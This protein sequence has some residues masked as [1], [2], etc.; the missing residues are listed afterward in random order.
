MV[1]DPGLVAEYLIAWAVREAQRVGD[2]SNAEL[3]R[4]HEVVTA[5][6][7]TDPALADLH[8]AVAA[9]HPVSE[10]TRQRVEAALR[11]TVGE[12]S[13][14]AETVAAL[15]VRLREGRWRWAGEL[16]GGQRPT[17]IAG[18][19]TLHA[20]RGAV[21]ALHV[22]S[23]QVGV[24]PPGPC[25]PGRPCDRP[26]SA[27][28]RRRPHGLPAAPKQSGGPGTTVRSICRISR[29]GRAPSRPTP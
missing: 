16:A 28:Q 5:K 23:L 12:D 24:P 14:F 19:V 25:P 13:T 17:T 4:L 15:A 11:T 21:A 10:L 7:G 9:G 29:R 6:L 3:D 27:P 2:Q 18:D 26:D 8:E 22:D 1:G 20:E